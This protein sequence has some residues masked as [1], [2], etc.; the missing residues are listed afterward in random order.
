MVRLWIE[1]PCNKFTMEIFEKICIESGIGYG[2][3]AEV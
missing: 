2:L 3:L 1:P